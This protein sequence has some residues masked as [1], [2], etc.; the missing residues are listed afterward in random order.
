MLKID[1]KK[2]L[3]G[4][5]GEMLLEAKLAIPEGE[6]VAITGESGSGKTT[7]LRILAGLEES[8]G[9]INFGKT[10]WQKEGFQL[11]IQKRHIG[12][13]FQDYA[14]FENMTVEENL[15]FVKKDRALAK[16]LLEITQLTELSQRYPNKLSGGQQQRV[17]L[18]RA[19]ISRPQLLLMDEPL[20]A[21]DMTMRSRLQDSIVQLHK[22]FNTTT[23]MVTHNP[24]EIY[25]M[26]SS[27]I[28]MHLG[29]VIKEGKA[30][31]VLIG[32]SNQL[33]G[34]VLAITKEYATLLV[35]GELI[36]VPTAL[37]GSL[38]IGEIVE[39]QLA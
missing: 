4:A 14:L 1:I 35:A 6:F 17:A 33:K 20:S 29:K 25:K 3:H 37:Y 34:E 39:V 8:S 27:V 13:V 18:A 7:L 2:R 26:S 23:I 19:F 12:F 15:L 22:E 28:V 11:P 30:Q 16:K 36:E 32:R 24:S 9:T 10:L 38:K 5:K 21:L 31:E